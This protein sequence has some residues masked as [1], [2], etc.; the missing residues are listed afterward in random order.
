MIAVPEQHSVQ[1]PHSTGSKD[2]T[3]P[4]SPCPVQSYENPNDFSQRKH[5]LHAIKTHA[6][7]MSQNN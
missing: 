4:T 1:G 7:L 6:A 2:E 5:L 3:P